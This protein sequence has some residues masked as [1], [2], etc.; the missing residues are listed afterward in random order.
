MIRFLIVT[1]VINADSLLV[2]TMKSISSQIGSENLFFVDYVIADAGR[3]DDQP[4]LVENY[5]SSLCF[6]ANINVTHINYKDKSMYDGLVNAIKN[7]K[8]NFDVFAYI[9]AGDM[10]SPYAFSIVA[11]IFSSNRTDALWLTG[12]TGSYDYNGHLYKLIEPVAYPRSLIKEGFFGKM[13]P[14]IQQES[15]FFSY[16]LIFSLDLDFLSGFKYAGDYYIW[17]TL[18]S[19]GVNLTVLPVWLSGFR[20]H[21]AQLSTVFNAKYK[22]EFNSI[23]T[24]YSFLSF[25]KCAIIAML[26]LVHPRLR[27]K[28]ITKW[29][30]KWS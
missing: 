4:S 17:N 11:D 29:V 19:E 15:T 26:N 14:Y 20:E 5:I 7:T 22:K 10:Y 3:T 30:R 2:D 24:S 1:P 13:L 6:P 9:N 8:G 12:C 21:D 23:R 18:A 27:P 16:P 25:F 28:K